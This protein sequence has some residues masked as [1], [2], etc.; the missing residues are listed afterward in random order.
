MFW[1]ERKTIN[2]AAVSNTMAHVSIGL[3]A[4]AL[5]TKPLQVVQVVVARVVINVVDVSARRNALVVIP[6]I[7]AY[8]VTSQHHIT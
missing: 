2:V 1:I 4:M 5:M 8:G 6:A 7:T 3:P